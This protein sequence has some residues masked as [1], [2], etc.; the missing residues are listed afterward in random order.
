MSHSLITN[1]FEFSLQLVNPKLTVPYWDFT[2]ETTSATELKYDPSQPNTRT[3]LL[4]S[5]WFGTTDLSDGMV[6][7]RVLLSAFTSSRQAL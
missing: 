2:I 6:R 5:L 7:E 4:S 1:T 3:E